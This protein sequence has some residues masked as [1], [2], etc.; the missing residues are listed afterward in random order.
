VRNPA[1][2]H[3]RQHAQPQNA[4]PNHANALL[5]IAGGQRQHRWLQVGAEQPAEEVVHLVRVGELSPEHC[6]QPP[7][8]P[9]LGRCGGIAAAGVYWDAALAPLLSRNKQIEQLKCL[10]ACCG[11]V[12]ETPASMHTCSGMMML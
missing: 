6:C 5:L 2:P 12:C 8:L 10:A 7:R 11:V 3:L 9:E 4:L 1:Q